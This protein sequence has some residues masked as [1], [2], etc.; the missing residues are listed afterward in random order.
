LALHEFPPTERK[1]IADNAIRRQQAILGG[2]RRPG[3]SRCDITI[4]ILPM[5]H[6]VKPQ[7]RDDANIC[8]SAGIRH[9]PPP[10]GLRAIMLTKSS[11]TVAGGSG[12]KSHCNAGPVQSGCHGG[13]AYRLIFWRSATSDRL[14]HAPSS[15]RR[16]V[17]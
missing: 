10:P 8:P 3:A 16:I 11:L 5:Q 7:S 17:A 15:S 6:D 4:A 14:D 13:S 9:Q 1:L 2:G 12:R